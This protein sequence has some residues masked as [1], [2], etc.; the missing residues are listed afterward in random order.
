M[1]S[2]VLYRFVIPVAA[3]VLLQG[4]ASLI[5]ERTQKVNIATSTGEKVVAKVDG[6][7]VEVPGVIGLQRAKA[8]KVLTTEDP[9]CTPATVVRSEVDIVF[10]INALSGGLGLF[11]S[12]TDMVSEK[13]WEY[14]DNILISC[15]ASS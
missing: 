12:T 2:C 9:R 11:G 8:D 3:V 13:M 6:M 10:F 15:K 4:C 14:D 7:M 5:N 1:N